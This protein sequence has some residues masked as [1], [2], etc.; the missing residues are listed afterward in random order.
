[1]ARDFAKDFYNSPTWKSTR[2]A[3]AKSVKLLC[4]DCLASGI[5][6]PGKIVH[7]IVH[8]TPENI[9]NPAITLNWKNL[10][11]VC[12]DCHAKEHQKDKNLKYCFD[13]NGNVLPLFEKRGTT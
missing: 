13:E 5:Y 11:L 10:K 2:M 9:G 3:Y 4:E 8:L 12:Q 6:T 7:H 1:M